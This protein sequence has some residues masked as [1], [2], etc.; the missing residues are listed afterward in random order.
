[1]NSYKSKEQQQLLHIDIYITYI[2]MHIYV[3]TYICVY[4]HAYIC[5]HT[6]DTV[7]KGYEQ[8]IHR[9]GSSNGDG[10]NLSRSGKCTLKMQGDNI[11]HTSNNIRYGDTEQEAHPFSDSRN[12]R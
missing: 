3:H 4:V 9:A 8:P 12:T 5:I 7:R 6:Y 2:S 1:M 10:H 11:Y